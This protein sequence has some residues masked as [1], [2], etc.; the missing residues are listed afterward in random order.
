MLHKIHLVILVFAYHIALQAQELSCS[1]NP[2][3]T[4]IG[5]VI[6][7]YFS[8]CFKEATRIQFTPYQETIPVIFYYQDEIKE[9]AL[10]I[11]EDFSD[12]IK[13]VGEQKVWQGHYKVIAWDIGRAVIAQQEVKINDSFY[14]FDELRFD[15]VGPTVGKA[16]ELFDIEE[17]QIDIPNKITFLIWLNKQLFWMLL[18]LLAGVGFVFYWLY[19]NKKRK[20][21]MSLKE[22]TLFIL[23]TLDRQDRSKKEQIKE[24]YTELSHITR[25][26]LS[27]RY[28]INLLVCTT[29]QTDFFLKQ[30]K[31]PPVVIDLVM[32]ILRQAD[33]VKFANQINDAYQPA[34]FSDIFQQIVA[35]TSPLEIEETTNSYF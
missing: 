29:H 22:R 23:R 10:E 4:K 14:L 31:V 34:Y 7:V 19:R 11:I 15:V 16:G 27:S 24:Y 2:T 26:Y 35:Q 5:S 17:G 28:Q 6:E 3:R 9:G 12:T 1:T 30:K 33:M 32:Q 8:I 21:V 18:V 20:K 13:S 25:A